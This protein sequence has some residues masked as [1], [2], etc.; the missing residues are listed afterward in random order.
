MITAASAS[1]LAVEA[2]ATTDAY[3]HLAR[4]IQRALGPDAGID[5]DT[6]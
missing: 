4:R 5:T 6:G 1:D 2:L 3:I